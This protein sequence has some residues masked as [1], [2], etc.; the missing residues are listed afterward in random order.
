MLKSDAGITLEGSPDDISEASKKIK[1][2]TA[3]PLREPDPAVLSMSNIMKIH[4]SSTPDWDALQIDPGTLGPRI[5]DPKGSLPSHPTITH[6][7][8]IIQKMVSMSGIENVFIS[9]NRDFVEGLV[10]GRWR[11]IISRFR[12][13]IFF[14]RACSPN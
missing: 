1:E 10:K 7:P 4:P 14:A 8:Q 12:S 5:K 3:P 9:N 11:S 2:R 6:P 13:S